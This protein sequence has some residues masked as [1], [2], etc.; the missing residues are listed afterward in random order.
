MFNRYDTGHTFAPH[1]DNAIRIQ[2]DGERS[3]R[4]DLAATL[5]LSE[6]EEYD[7]GELTVE[8]TYGS[9]EVKLPAGDLILYPASSVHQVMPIT[10]G[11]RLSHLFSGFKA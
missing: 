1:V 4:T 9:H 3:V 5:F 10:R 6:P 2:R 11:A 7:G 8:D